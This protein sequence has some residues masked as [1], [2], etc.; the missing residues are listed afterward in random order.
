M[1]GV[2]WGWER[3]K[4]EKPQFLLTTP[5]RWG[6]A[7]L[8]VVLGQNAKCWLSP[9]HPSLVRGWLCKKSWFYLRRC[10]LFHKDE[11]AWASSLVHS[12]QEGDCGWRILLLTWRAIETMAKFLLML[13]TF[14]ALYWFC[15][16]LPTLMI[17]SKWLGG[18]GWKL[19]NLIKM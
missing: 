19:A 13:S 17:K 12:K 15:Q 8:R 7:I 14:K 10:P 2:G 18:R 6:R 9:E 1:T 5:C 11:A 4:R 16:A 3:F